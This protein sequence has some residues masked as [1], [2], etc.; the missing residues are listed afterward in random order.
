MC[1]INVDLIKTLRKNKNLSQKELGKLLGI[2]DRAVS[3]W[4]LG[5]TKPTAKN[6]SLLSK[7]F[8]VSINDFFMKV[9]QKLITKKLKG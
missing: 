1:Y 9:L 4:E 6:L 2:S 7:I 8:G 5:E 3:R